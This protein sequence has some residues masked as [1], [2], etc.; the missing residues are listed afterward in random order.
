MMAIHCPPTVVVVGGSRIIVV[1][2]VVVVVIVCCY[3][4][5]VLVCF[6]EVLVQST[7]CITIWRNRGGT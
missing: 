1:I 5:I 2:V 3:C 6:G 7:P 4:Y